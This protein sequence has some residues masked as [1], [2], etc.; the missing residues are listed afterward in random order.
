[1]VDD[2]FSISKR[3]IP[4]REEL[5]NNLNQESESVESFNNLSI[6]SEFVVM[7]FV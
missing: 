3:N 7:V 2:L 4:I 5:E 1:M 6:S